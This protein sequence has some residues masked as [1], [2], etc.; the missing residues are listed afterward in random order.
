MFAQFFKFKVKMH[1]LP[2]LI[3]KLP[4]EVR[5]LIKNITDL[6]SLCI[7]FFFFFYW[8][9]PSLE[10]LTDTILLQVFSILIIYWVIYNYIY[11]PASQV[12]RFIS[13]AFLRIC[14]FQCIGIFVLVNFSCWILTKEIYWVNSFIMTILYLNLMLFSRLAVRQLFRRD[15]I[16]DKRKLLIHGISNAAGD[17]ASALTFSSRFK[18]VG[19]IDPTNSKKFKYLAG[20]PVFAS[21]EL[22]YLKTS[23]KVNLIIIDEKTLPQMEKRNLV[24]YYNNRG[25][26]LKYAP[27]IDRA[28]EY[29]GQLKSISPEELLGR[30]P[31]LMSDEIV[32]KNIKNKITLVTGAGG[33]IGSELCRQIVHS[34][35][36]EL[37][38]LDMNEF[39][40]YSISQELEALKANN[41]LKVK[42]TYIIGSCLNEALLKDIF[43]NNKIDTIFHSAAY[44]HVPL[45]E[46]NICTGVENNVFGTF[47][48]AEMA[49]KSGV[50]SF[51][52]ISSDKAVRPTNIMGASKRITELICQS[53]DC[54]NTNFSVV[55]FGNVL[56]SS[57][58]VIPKFK[59]QI[60]KGGPVTVTD[61]NITRYF[62]TISEA[63]RLVLSANSMS[64]GGEVFVLDMGQPIKI[65]DLA[66]SM[67]RLHGLIPNLK[68]L[69]KNS[70]LLDEI[71]II[72][73]GLRPGEKLYEEL[74]I[75]KNTSKTK[76][77]RIIS[78]VEV[79][80]DKF[81]LIGIINRLRKLI[82]SQNDKGIVKLLK[83]LP[84]DYIEK[85]I[86]HIN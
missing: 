36:A 78:S 75:G 27:S 24:E 26:S 9:N 4:V 84:I 18:V 56:G 11:K 64:K 13:V 74:F 52:L 42:L 86:D 33:S 17:L 58:S 21:N 68:N 57:G 50:P 14:I 43:N 48:L 61:K 41:S 1:L 35:A 29:E 22:D 16:E 34:G 32:L 69:S 5:F 7:V 49:V 12:T 85:E 30:E 80:I 73:T 37:I 72:F 67:I 81:E 46:E 2:D 38:L 25:F 47:A 82:K 70:K 15:G 53:Y 10:K 60:K 63:S 8:E 59:E 65:L 54:D 66:K 83:K 6:M 40:V 19:F 39:A 55:R 51:T 20:Y 71:R 3:S 31:V 77:P 76:H 79:T 45:M 44:K 62:M 23:Q 28:F